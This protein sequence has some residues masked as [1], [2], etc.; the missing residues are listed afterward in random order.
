MKASD[1][2][3]IL[4][5]A[6]ITVFV[7]RKITMESQLPPLPPGTKGPF[8]NFLDA[9][10]PDTHFY[11]PNPDYD[12]TDQDSPPEK[13]TRTPAFHFYRDH[14]AGNRGGILLGAAAGVGAIVAAPVGIGV[15]GTLAVVGIGAAIGS[16]IEDTVED[17][18]PWKG[19]LPFV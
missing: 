1:A 10:W 15:V 3:I 14:I 12:P 7:T 2:L 13:P 5:V 4:T 9:L 6:G 19:W 17:V 16:A 18:K 11:E 8:G